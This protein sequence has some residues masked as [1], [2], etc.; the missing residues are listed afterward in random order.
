MNKSIREPLNIEEILKDK[1][2]PRELINKLSNKL[3]P[4]LIPKNEYFIDYNQ[5]MNKIGIIVSGLLV[6]RYITDDGEE[7]T[8]KFYYPNGDGIVVDFYCFKNQENSNEQIRAIE[9]SQL[10]TLSY[11]D[12]QSLLSDSLMQKLIVTLTEESYLKALSRIRDFQQLDTIKRV[13]K[14]KREN[15]EV[16]NKLP[17][18]DMSSYLGMNRN[19]FSENMKKIR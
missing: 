1:N 16:I 6:S 14:F 2:F 11:I 12:Y 7:I 17:I 18:K 4:V 10:Y 13:E 19:R 15:K 5:K 9:D 8:S 3:K